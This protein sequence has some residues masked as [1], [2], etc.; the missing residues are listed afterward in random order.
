MTK[1][2]DALRQAEVERH[3]RT[4]S[5]VS[6]TA[7]FSQP[8]QAAQHAGAGSEL[9][10]L[11]EIVLGRLARDFQQTM[12]RLENRIAAEETALRAELGKLEQRLE[13]RLVEVD[14]RSCQA[15][16]QLRQLVLS[17]S[18]S[19]ND[20]IKERS[21]D[22]IRQVNGGLDVLRRD[23][24]SGAEFSAFL[25]GLLEHLDGSRRA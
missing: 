12:A 25:S 8:G 7:L 20:S 10:R 4:E 11:R 15:Q 6:T 2:Y 17:Q 9:E 19:L 22:A 16:A 13:D 5:P 23:K 14:T 1:V 18:N 21:A 3:E 24:L